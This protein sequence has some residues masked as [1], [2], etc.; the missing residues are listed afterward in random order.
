MS[1]SA[2]NC[3]RKGGNVLGLLSSCA[4]LWHCYNIT[5]FDFVYPCLNTSAKKTPK[6]DNCVGY[7]STLTK[8][9]KM[10][11]MVKVLGSFPH[12]ERCVSC[13]VCM[14]FLVLLPFSLPESHREVPLV[15]QFSL[16]PKDSGS[17]TASF[18]PKVLRC[19]PELCFSHEHH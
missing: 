2:C 8:V 17:V 11:E 7:I 13:F 16:L 12:R 6:G 4:H 3:W 5:A 15:S 19:H 1:L 18:F 9:H 14:A 10:T